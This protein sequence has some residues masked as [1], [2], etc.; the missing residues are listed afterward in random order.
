MYYKTHLKHISK[1]KKEIE[2]IKKILIL[3]K[4]LFSNCMLIN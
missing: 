3:Q 1:Y 2:I 4:I